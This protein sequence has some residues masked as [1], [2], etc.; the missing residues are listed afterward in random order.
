MMI[1]ALEYRSSAKALNHKPRTAHLL[2]SRRPSPSSSQ[3]NKNGWSTHECRGGRNS[4][5]AGYFHLVFAMFSNLQLIVTCQFLGLLFTHWIADSLTL[6]KSPPTQTD[7]R[8][9]TAATYYSILTRLPPV[10]LYVYG[11]VALLGAATLLWSLG[12]GRAGNF[13]FDGGSIRE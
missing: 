10:L 2:S 8:L 11:S 1:W 6:W 3:A 13:M 7:A 9:W 4:L 12:D 5:F